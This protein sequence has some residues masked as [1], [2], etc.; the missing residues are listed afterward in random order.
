MTK[1]TILYVI[2]QGEWGGAQRYIFDLATNL[3]PNFDAIVAVGE[4]KGK[5]DLQNKLTIHNEQ[6]TKKVV[7]V[8][9]KHLVRRISLYHDFRAILELKKLYQEWNRQEKFW[10]Y[11]HPFLFYIIFE[12]KL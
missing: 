11:F 9:L 7:V 2:T 12:F 1:K 8:Q 10:N 6:S 3:P 4:P 5:E